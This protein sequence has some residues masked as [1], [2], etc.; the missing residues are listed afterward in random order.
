MDVLGDLWRQSRQAARY[1]L[2]NNKLDIREYFVS[3]NE[4]NEDRQ[5]K[6]F[7]KLLAERI[8]ERY[9]AEN[10]VLSSHLVA[11]SVFQMLR[12][13]KIP[14]L[15]IFGILRL[16]SDEYI[17]PKSGRRGNRTAPA[18]VCT[19]WKNKGKFAWIQR[20]G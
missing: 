16:P 10:V 13:D 3:P 2:H 12:H 20:Y 4:V 11:Y 19:P 14:K 8:E 17:S 7:T 18:S 6:E 1:D 9:L 15:D 5:R